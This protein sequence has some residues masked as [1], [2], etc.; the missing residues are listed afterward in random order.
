M[1]TN[2]LKRKQKLLQMKLS[3][4]NL[5]YI[6]TTAFSGAPRARIPS[7]CLVDLFCFRWDKLAYITACVSRLPPDL[8]L[9]EKITHC[10]AFHHPQKK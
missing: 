8:R 1:P 10:F 2:V 7:H 6:V 9:Y 5:R 4:L 3:K